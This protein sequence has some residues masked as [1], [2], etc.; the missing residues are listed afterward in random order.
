MQNSNL[1]KELQEEY[2]RGHLALQ[3]PPCKIVARGFNPST[4]ARYMAL[5]TECNQH[6]VLMHDGG[7][8]IVL[9]PTDYERIE[10]ACAVL[11]YAESKRLFEGDWS[12]VGVMR[13]L[14]SHEPSSAYTVTT[15]YGIRYDFPR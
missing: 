13:V 6:M 14:W 7:K 4:G 12:A 10:C 9:V 3:A 15:K 11:D 8:I 2:E 5:E 1:P